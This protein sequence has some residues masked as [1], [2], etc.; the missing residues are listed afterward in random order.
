MGVPFLHPTLPTGTD[1]QLGW[2]RMVSCPYE[3]SNRLE[4]GQLRFWSHFRADLSNDHKLPP[5]QPGESIFSETIQRRSQRPKQMRARPCAVGGALDQFK[6]RLRHQFRCGLPVEE[7]AMGPI[8]QAAVGVTEPACA[9]R[10]AIAPEQQVGQCNDQCSSRR[11]VRTDRA[12]QAPRIHQMLQNMT[13]D[14]AVKLSEI[15]DIEAVQIG[16]PDPFHCVFSPGCFLSGMGDAGDLRRPIRPDRPGQRSVTAPNVENTPC[17]PGNAGEHRRVDRAV[18]Q[19]PR[20]FD[21]ATN[22]SSRIST[23]SGGG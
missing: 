13:T 16:Q 17:S 12:E 18:D 23:G 20:H 10:Q 15:Y 22:S 8:H 3:P 2:S 4:S 14:D 7:F 11:K 5:E 21:R 1:P 19:F 6:V 9:H